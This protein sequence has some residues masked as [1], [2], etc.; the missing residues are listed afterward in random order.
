M[1]D[2]AETLPPDHLD[3][4]FDPQDLKRRSVQGGAATFGAQALKFFIRF[5]S[6]VV[7]ARF[8]TR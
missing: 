5:G 8:L 4:A 3:V 2:S 1:P 7:V 6:A